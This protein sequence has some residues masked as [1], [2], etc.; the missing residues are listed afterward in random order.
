MQA[1]ASVI[2]ML[3]AVLQLQRAALR[4]NSL[5]SDELLAQVVLYASEQ[6]ETAEKKQIVSL[7]Y[8]LLFCSVNSD[9]PCIS[10]VL[11]HALPKHK[12]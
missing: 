11:L 7:F 5:P 12:P 1:S 2:C 8:A 4:L 6:R 10:G 9:S 3:L